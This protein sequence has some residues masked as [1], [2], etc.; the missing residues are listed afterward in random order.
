MPQCGADGLRFGLLSYTVQG[1]DVNLDV[2]RVFGYR[3]FCNKL[4]NLFKFAFTMA[5]LGSFKASSNLDVEIMQMKLSERDRWILSRCANAAKSTK[6][7]IE[8]YHFGDACAAVY[9][10]FLNELCNVYVELVKPVLKSNDDADVKEAARATLYVCL[11]TGLRL[12]HPIMP[13]ITEELYQRLGRRDGDN[14][15]TISLA[16]YPDPD[17]QEGIKSW[18]DE[19]MDAKVDAVMKVTEGFLKIRGNYL[20][21]PYSRKTPSAYVMATEGDVRLPYI[22][23]QASDVMTLA[24]LA[25][26]TIVK[27]AAEIPEGCCAE[28]IDGNLQLYVQLKGI[29]DFGKEVSKLNKELA[30]L[31]GMVKKIE[32]KVT[33]PGYEKVPIEVKTGDKEKLVMYQSKS[34]V[35][36]DTIDMFNKLSL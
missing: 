10:F 12:L 1:R 20:S 29:V 14:T 6:D 25:S 31:E 26:V 5:D 35:V 2:Q 23:A 8:G 22:A 16:A 3:K 28:P 9:N 27:S 34:K 17:K 36:Q 13:F 30:K 15:E 19:E 24:K 18:F 33:K 11:D 32:T 21:G 4:W 7:N